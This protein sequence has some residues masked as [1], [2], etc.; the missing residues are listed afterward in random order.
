MPDNDLANPP[1][2][3]IFGG[4]S[5]IGLALAKR[6]LADGWRVTVVGSRADKI[7][8]IRNTYP[9]IQALQCD[10]TS[11][12]QRR[13][14]FYQLED[15]TKPFFNRVIYSAGWYLNERK[16]QL[17]SHDSYKM[18]AINLQAFNDM[19]L[20]ASEVLT[21]Q[22]NYQSLNSTLPKPTLICLASIAGMMTYPYASLY[23]RCKQAMIATCD[24]YRL[25]LKPFNI[26]VNCI[27]SGYIDT[28]SLRDLN[29]GDARHKPFI[30]SEALATD[31]MMT[32]INDNIK[33][34]IFPKPMRYLVQTLNTLPKPLLNFLMKKRLD[35]PANK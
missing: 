9:N 1:S 4:T 26:Q 21:A 2:V 20:W 35:K 29:H 7:D 32:A 25:A 14:L 27:A 15:D 30:I 23:A 31:Y 8:K 5:G 10:L 3:L 11:T 17:N 6:H 34:A 24:A 19:M 28:Q 33:L 16:L 22:A 13:Q 18:L 12:C